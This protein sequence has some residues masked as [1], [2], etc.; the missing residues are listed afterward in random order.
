MTASGCTLLSEDTAAVADPLP[1]LWGELGAVN[2]SRHVHKTTGGSTHLRASGGAQGNSSYRELTVIDGD[3]F[4]YGPRT[5]LGLNEWQNGENSG[6][7][8]NGTFALYKEGDHKITFFSM[9]FGAG[10]TSTS[11]AWQIVGQIRATQPCPAWGPVNGSP[12]LEFVV[13]EG[14][15][16]LHS[17]WV[18]KWETTPPANGVWF[19]VA[20]DVTYSKDPTKGKVQMFVDNN[21]DG[22]FLDAD[23]VSPVMTMATLSYAAVAGNG[24]AIDDPI[25][26][27]LRLGPYHDPWYGT[28]TVDVDNVQVV[29]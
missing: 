18:T 15:F 12:A 14:K 25:P 4:G 21:G 7:Q 28:T 26:S 20:V 3:D 27:H 8:T 6:S 9:R 24:F 16:G 19:R 13:D 23:E 17:N 11:S 1:G 10:F 22:D 2:A 29:G 5:E